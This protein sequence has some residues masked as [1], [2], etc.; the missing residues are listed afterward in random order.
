MNHCWSSEQVRDEKYENGK[1]LPAWHEP[2][3]I[4]TIVAF[5]ATKSGFKTS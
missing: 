1:I 2:Y 4:N 3:K 5:Y